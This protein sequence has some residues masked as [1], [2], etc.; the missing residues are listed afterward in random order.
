MQHTPLDFK[1][2]TIII[3]LTII[4]MFAT[5]PDALSAEVVT[6]NMS[7]QP[8]DYNQEEIDCLAMNIYHEAR[9]EPFGGKAAVGVVTMNRLFSNRY[10]NTVCKVVWQ[11]TYKRYRFTNGGRYIPQ[12]SWTL[13]GK[14]D[15]AYNKKA[16]ARAHKLAR[17]IYMN[18]T[19]DNIKWLKHLHLNAKFSEALFYHADYVNPRWGRIKKQTGKYI[20]TIGRHLFYV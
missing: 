13:D 2:A 7:E 17:L 20:N 19:Q 18:Y 1:T 12:F 5:T 16:Y 6:I 3:L 8:R 10:P 11:K 15:K 9:N 4:V 14:P